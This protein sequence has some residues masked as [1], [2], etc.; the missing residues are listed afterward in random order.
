MSTHLQLRQ[1]VDDKKEVNSKT[2]LKQEQE[3]SVNP[4]KTEITQTNVIMLREKL[5]KAAMQI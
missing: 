3:Q 5:V 4:G 1:S 2:R